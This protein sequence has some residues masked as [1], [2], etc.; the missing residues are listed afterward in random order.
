MADGHEF[1]ADAVDPR[2]VLHDYLGVLPAGR[3]GRQGVAEQLDEAADRHPGVC[4]PRGDAGGHGADKGEI[5]GAADRLLGVL[6]L[7]EVLEGEDDAER[8]ARLVAQRGER[9]A[10]LDRASVRGPHDRL[11]RQGKAGAAGADQDGVEERLVIGGL[12][13]DVGKPPADALGGGAAEIFLAT[14]LKL[15]TTPPWLAVTTPPSR[16]WSV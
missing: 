16:L 7:G 5:L 14:G 9:V 10:E 6:V 2:D 1:A 4:G 13:E 12:G 3:V 15:V 8:A 11:G